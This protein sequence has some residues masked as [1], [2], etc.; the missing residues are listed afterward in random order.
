MMHS[1][2]DIYN[3][4]HTHA[5]SYTVCYLGMGW[6]LTELCNGLV[7]FCLLLGKVLLVEPKQLLALSVLLL[8]AWGTKG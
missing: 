6:C 1:L 8:Q 7:E 5:I 4:K 2:Q 3:L